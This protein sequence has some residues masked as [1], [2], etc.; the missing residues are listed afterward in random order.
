M[1]S[2]SAFVRDAGSDGI[3]R[4]VVTDAITRGALPVA[5]LPMPMQTIQPQAGAFLPRLFASLTL[6]T[7][8]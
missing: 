6:R 7:G 3:G 4:D 1:M 5:P 2:S 8:N